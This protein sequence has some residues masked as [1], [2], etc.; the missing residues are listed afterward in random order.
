MKSKSKM[1]MAQK[2]N[3]YGEGWTRCHLSINAKRT[4]AWNKVTCKKCLKA[5]TSQEKE[6]P[7]GDKK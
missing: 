5:Q 3:V 4:N 7:S 2:I 1:H 6:Q